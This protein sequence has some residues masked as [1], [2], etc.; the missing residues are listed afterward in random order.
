MKGVEYVSL[1]SWLVGSSDV[2]APS[3]SCAPSDRTASGVGG[4]SE[5]EGDGASVGRGK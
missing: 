2:G 3:A 1:D 4:D 5:G